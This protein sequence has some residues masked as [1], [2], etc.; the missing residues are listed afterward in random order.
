MEIIGIDIGFGFTK[1]TNGRQ[2]LVFKSVLGEA[3]DIQFQEKVMDD[4]E[5]DDHLQVEIDGKPW[6]AVEVKVNETN[7]APTMLYYKRKLNIPFCY[8]VV[9][10]PGVDILKDGVR[11]VSADRFLLSLM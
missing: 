1:V 6:F 5:S 10:K 8:Q 7:V 2:E 4:D 9:Q 11:V 3:T